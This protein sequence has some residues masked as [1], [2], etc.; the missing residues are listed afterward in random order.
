[1]LNFQGHAARDAAAGATSTSKLDLLTIWD[2][3]MSNWASCRG[4]LGHSLRE[5]SVETSPLGPDPA[6]GTTASGTFETS[7]DAAAMAA[8]WRNAAI[9]PRAIL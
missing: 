1:M 7:T 9:Q 6:P 2:Y 3:A 8:C 5:G 4:A